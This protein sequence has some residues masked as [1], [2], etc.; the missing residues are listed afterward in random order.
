M[1][2]ATANVSYIQISLEEF[3][4]S[5]LQT[6]PNGFVS[7]SIFCASHILRRSHIPSSAFAPLLNMTFLNFT[8]VTSG[9]FAWTLWWVIWLFIPFIN[10]T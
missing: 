2:I 5:A 3:D 1:P 7:M 6:V 10:L 9:L 8:P 4:I